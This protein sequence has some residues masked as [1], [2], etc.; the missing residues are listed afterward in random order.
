METVSKPFG[1]SKYEWYR[2]KS[3]VT[4]T[5]KMGRKEH[6][7]KGDKFGVRDATSKKGVKR[8]IVDMLGKNIVF[9]MKDVV[10]DHL[11]KK[12]T[13]AASAAGSQKNNRT[14]V[15][16]NARQLLPISRCLGKACADTFPRDSRKVYAL[17]EN[18]STRLSGEADMEAAKD[19]V[20]RAI[21]SN[22][23]QATKASTEVIA[24][25]EKEE[26]KPVKYSTQQIKYILRSAAI[27]CLDAAKTSTQAKKYIN[28]FIG[29]LL[30]QQPSWQN[31]IP[32]LQKS[33]YQYYM[34]LR[35]TMKRLGTL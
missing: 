22:Y 5:S 25:K 10:A 30:N 13:K 27:A 4:L 16:I 35:N 29:A 2:L 8:V 11:I 24:E 3:P 14:K 28:D 23:Q 34:K 18:F 33:T 7:R 15:T 6:L 9:S 32:I 17:S 12:A 19:V 21:F 20:T 26:E 1:K 31:N